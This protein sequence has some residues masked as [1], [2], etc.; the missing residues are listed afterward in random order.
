MKLLSF[1]FVTL[2]TSVLS[3]V[4]VQAA[5]SKPVFLYSRYFNAPGE[6][7]YLPDGSYKD[8][9]QRLGKNFDVRVNDCL[10]QWAAQVQ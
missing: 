3:V 4:A 8:L 9:L 1:H 2:W 6:S 5:D 10:V 7:R